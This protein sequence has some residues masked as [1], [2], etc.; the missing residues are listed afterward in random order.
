MCTTICLRN[1]E[2]RIVGKNYDIFYDVGY[3]FTNQRSIAKTALIQPPADDRPVIQDLQW[4]HICLI[5]S[6]KS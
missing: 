3:L 5:K 6:I 1:A 2:K 4:I